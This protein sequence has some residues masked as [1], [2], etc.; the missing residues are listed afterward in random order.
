M[1][2]PLHE[3]EPDDRLSVDYWETLLDH[4]IEITGDVELPLK[5]SSE[6]TPKHWGIGSYV[7]LTSKTIA[8]SSLSLGRVGHLIVNASDF[9]YRI[10]NG[11]ICVRWL[12]RENRNNPVYYF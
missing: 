6:A 4:A 7:A 2:K 11:K 9:S 12:P 5:V 1:L 10:E 3:S 8:E